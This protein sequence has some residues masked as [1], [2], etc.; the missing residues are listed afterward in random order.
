MD[1]HGAATLEPDLPPAT[2]MPRFEYPNQ[3]VTVYPGYADATSSGEIRGLINSCL[4]ESRSPVSGSLPAVRILWPQPGAV[5]L[6]S[7]AASRTPAF[8]EWDRARDRRTWRDNKR[9]RPRP[10]ARKAPR[11][12]RPG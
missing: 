6:P 5:A 11:R 7:R 1:L 10:H 9:S 3:A 4:P 2:P 8:P 12:H